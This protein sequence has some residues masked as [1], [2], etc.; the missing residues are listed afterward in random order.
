MKKKE[1]GRVNRVRPP[2]EQYQIKLNFGLSPHTQEM[3]SLWMYAVT[4]VITMCVCMCESSMKRL[5][6][7]VEM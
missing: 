5:K 1:G 7:T 4:C 3:D 6:E 2:A